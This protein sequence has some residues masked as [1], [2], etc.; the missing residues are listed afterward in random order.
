MK[1]K[2]LLALL[3]EGYT[4]IEVTFKD[5][6]RREVREGRP[7]DEDPYR[8]QQHAQPRA[9]KR[10][11]YKAKL[12][13]KVE[14]GDSVVVDSTSNGMVVMDV[15]AVHA[16]PKI[17]LDAPFTYK[18]IVQKVDAEGY[19]RTLEQ[20][21]KFHQVMLEIERVRQRELLMQQFTANLP[22]GSE[23][24]KLF[25]DATAKLLKGEVL[26]GNV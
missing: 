7:W 10:Y 1:H 14:V 6:D 13:D 3:Q 5:T 19:K 26:D 18:W 24:R 22:E 11:T 21:D 20:E 23:A 16:T 17:D 9:P 4:T 15:V 12:A 25:D 2:H 8:A